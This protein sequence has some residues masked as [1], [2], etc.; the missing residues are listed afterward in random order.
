MPAARAAWCSTSD[1]GSG[2]A[3]AWP[4]ISART[5][6]NWASVSALGATATGPRRPGALPC[7]TSRV[8]VSSDLAAAIVAVTPVPRIRTVVPAKATPTSTGTP[9]GKTPGTVPELAPPISDQARSP[10]VSA[11]STSRFAGDPG[12]VICSRYLP[13][14]V[15]P[16]SATGPRETTMSTVHSSV[17]G[18]PDGATSSVVSH[19]GTS[20]TMPGLMYTP[21]DQGI[22]SGAATP[23]VNMPAGGTSTPYDGTRTTRSFD[24]IR[25]RAA[26][27]PAGSS[28][29][30]EATGPVPAY[31]STASPA[32]TSSAASSAIASTA[33]TVVTAYIGSDAEGQVVGVA[34]TEPANLTTSLTVTLIRA[35]IAQSG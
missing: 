1:T 25:S 27:A 2:V 29:G 31:G 21:V 20:A 23:K 13:G 30:H 18:H 7:S 17:A 28:I 4:S 9:T 19:T 3:S 26:R 34:D 15:P 24:P 16:A 11:S 12:W 5:A 22:P 32:S 35:P 8:S 6:E 33:V 10:S 14:V